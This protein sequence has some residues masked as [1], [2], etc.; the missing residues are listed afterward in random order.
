MFLCHPRD[1]P[2]CPLF[3]DN[4]LKSEPKIVKGKRSFA[5]CQTIMSSTVVDQSCIEGGEGNDI[6]LIKNILAAGWHQEEQPIKEQTSVDEAI[7][8][9]LEINTL[10]DALT[11][12]YGESEPGSTTDISNSNSPVSLSSTRLNSRRNSPTTKDQSLEKPLY[13]TPLLST[14][15]SEHNS[16]SST[17]FS[18]SAEDLSLT[19]PSTSTSSN[20]Q[21]S[22]YSSGNSLAPPH[23]AKSVASSELD[24][25]KSVH[26]FAIDFN[27][28]DM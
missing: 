22:S 25:A 3:H 18:T 20:F 15:F 4:T 19:T 12:L 7:N 26:E 17:P 6:L 16:T 23:K 24:K 10:R 1:S 13:G 2:S 27:I 28:R 8:L 21:L 14:L 9:E 11:R 5:F